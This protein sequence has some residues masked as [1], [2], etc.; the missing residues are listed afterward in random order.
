MTAHSIQIDHLLNAPIIQSILDIQFSIDAPIRND[1]IRTLHSIIKEEYPTVEPSKSLAINEEIPGQFI[2]KDG[3]TFTAPEKYKSLA[4]TSSHMNLTQNYPYKDWDDFSTGFLNCWKALA[5]I[6]NPI[7]I[8][9]ISTRFVNKIDVAGPVQKI[10]TIFTS[11]LNIPDDFP[12]T[13][14]NFILAYTIPFEEERCISN[15][16]ETM[17]AP[18]NQEDISLILDIDVLDLNA[19]DYNID[20][21]VLKLEKLHSLK[22]Y[23]FKKCLTEETY[24]KLK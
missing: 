9:R 12:Q 2:L 24:N 13:I 15:I 11:Y 10:E 1:A 5:K 19:F 7:K 8:N 20:E 18:I 4:A 22:N 17:G 6:V 23:I 3:Y 16:I 14:N 21:V